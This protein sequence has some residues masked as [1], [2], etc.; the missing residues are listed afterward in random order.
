MGDDRAERVE[1]MI[2]NIEKE[3]EYT[4]SL[5]SYT[6]DAHGNRVLVGLS[7]Q[8]TAELK[9]LERKSLRSRLLQSV[10]FS[11]EEKGRLSELLKKY[12]CARLQVI[13][14]EFELEKTKPTKN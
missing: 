4:S 8:E 2:E 7:L 3:S 12:E 10:P 5:R 13:G 6:T 11:D 9:E 1:K 14:A